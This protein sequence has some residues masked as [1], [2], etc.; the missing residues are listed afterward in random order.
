MCIIFTTKA[1]EFEEKVKAGKVEDQ[2]MD[3]R[4]P[5]DTEAGSGLLD[6]S[7]S[8]VPSISAS[9]LGNKTHSMHSGNDLLSLSQAESQQSAVISSVQGMNTQAFFKPL[10]TAPVT[11]LSE[12]QGPGSTA[13]LLQRIPSPLN[14]RKNISGKSL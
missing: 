6:M 9:T 2:D 12:G 14:V 13:G 1:K 10:Q 7:T 8:S 4:T 11:V 5:M 3:H